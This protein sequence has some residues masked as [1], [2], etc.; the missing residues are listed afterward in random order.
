[1]KYKGK[2]RIK[3]HLDKELNDFPRDE[4]G[5]IDSSYD[6]IYI[7]C[8]NGSQIYHVGRSTL[9][10]YIPSIGRGHNIIIAIAKELNIIEDESIYRDYDSL[11]SILNADKTI[12]DITENDEEIEFKF[13]AKDIELITKYLKPQTSGADI[14][15]FSSRNLPKSSYAIPKENL[16]EYAEITASIPQEDKLKVGLITSRFINDILSKDKVY[17]TVNIKTDMRKKCLKGKEYIHYMGYWDKYIYY[18]RKECSHGKT[19]K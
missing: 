14:S 1:M 2:Y 17:R 8:A 16:E 12:F 5:S 11:Y 19:C 3:P 13:N 6:D 9:C 4:Y 10:A 7:K 15:P 18:L